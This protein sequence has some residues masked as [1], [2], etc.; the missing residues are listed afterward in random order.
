EAEFQYNYDEVLEKSILF[1]EAERSGRLPANNRIPYRG[2]S[3][4]GDQGNQGQDLTGGW[5]DAGD[6]V[7]FG[8]PMAFATTT[9]A[10]GIL[11]FRDGYEAAGQY[12]LALD[13]IRWTLNYFLKAHVSDNEFYGQ[14]GDA[15]TDHAYWGRPEDMTMERPAWS[16]S[17]SAPGSDLAAETAAA[18]A[19]GYLV[20][21]DSDAAFANNLLAHSRTLY[22]FALNNRGIYSQSISNAAGFYASS[23]YEDELAWGAAWLYRATEE[24]EYLDRAYEFGTT[25]NTA[26]AYDW[27]EKIVGYQLLLTTSAGQTDF[28]PRVEN[29]LR[30]WFPGGSVQ[31]TPLGLAWLAQWGPNRYAANAAFIALV[32]AKYNILASESEQFARSQIHYMLGDAGRSYV[33]GFGNNPPQQPHHRSSSCPD[34]PAECDWDEFNQPG[35]NYQIL[36]GALVGGPDQNDQFEDLRSDYIRNEVANDYNAG[37]QG[38]VAALRAIQLRDGKFLEQKLISE[39]DLNSAVDHHHHHH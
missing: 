28:L 27:N 17:P 35:P 23:A 38:A 24:Q 1:Y 22:D 3:A 26:W 16:I 21:R 15:N 5:Y 10:W 6:H 34:Q 12:N 33:V 31:Y 18:L 37:F 39:E 2:D 9:L 30:N 29:F 32:S 20:F 25:T 14:V 13:S 4:L 36:Y 8:F 11:E 7:K 19:A